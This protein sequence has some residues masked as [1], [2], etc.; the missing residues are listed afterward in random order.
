M[1]CG[2]STSEWDGVAVALEDI[3]FPADKEDLVKHVEAKPADEHTVKLIRALPVATYANISE[4]RSSVRLDPAADD[5]ED[6]S[7]RAARRHSSH[8][9]HIAPHLRDR[10]Q[11]PLDED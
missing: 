4:I 1:P 3:D 2:M 6:A 11:P 8:S 5:G 7:E 10:D 9:E